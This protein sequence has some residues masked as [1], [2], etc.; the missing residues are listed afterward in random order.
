[1]TDPTAMS[2]RYRYAGKGLIERLASRI[3]VDGPDG[4]WWWQGST[5][6]AGYGALEFKGRREYVHRWVHEICIGPIPDGMVVDHL[7]DNP[8]CVRPDHLEAKTQRE[9][10]LRGRSLSALRARATH[11]PRG[12]K[13][14]EANTY[15]HKGHRRCRA[16]HR[17]TVRRST[18]RLRAP[19]VSDGAVESGHVSIGSGD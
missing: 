5:T 3:T 4:C 15:E 8:R 10:V 14:D 13:Y 18:A 12:H 7:C 17:E 19:K 1:M 16:C 11:C 2:D 9:N 6:P